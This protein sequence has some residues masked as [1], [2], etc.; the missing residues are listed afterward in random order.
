MNNTDQ[1][2]QLFVVLIFLIIAYF[3]VMIWTR[4]AKNSSEQ[5]GGG[6]LFGGSGGGRG[7]MYGGASD[8]GGAD[9][10]EDGMPARPKKTGKD[11]N[12]GRFELQGHDAEIAAKVL[13]RMLKQDA[14]FKKEEE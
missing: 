1:A 10:G 13:K 3:G 11:R 4:R 9:L 2:I 5:G 7:S 6:G 14:G 8:G 12:K